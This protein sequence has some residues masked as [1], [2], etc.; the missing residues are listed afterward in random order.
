VSHD[1][2]HVLIVEARYPGSWVRDETIEKAL[3]RR[4]VHGKVLVARCSTNTIVDGL[5][6]V[7][8]DSVEWIAQAETTADRR[9]LKNVR[10]DFDPF[11][12]DAPE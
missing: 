10:L 7:Y 11:M 2:P 3:T 4:Q 5:G 9:R 12:G 8:G 6:R 1:H